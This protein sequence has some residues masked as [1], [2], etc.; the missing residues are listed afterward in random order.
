MKKINSFFI[1]LLSFSF[2]L[3]NCSLKNPFSFNQKNR[4]LS[5]VADKDLNIK[6]TIL[7]VQAIS[8]FEK[9]FGAIIKINADLHTIFQ[10]DIIL[11]YKVLK[12]TK[13]QVVLVKNDKSIV[14][15][16]NI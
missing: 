4:S 3:S 11:G 2:V 13:D 14:L 6:K 12:I 15:E 5:L 10:G 16:L 1:A 8:T 9:K 7:S